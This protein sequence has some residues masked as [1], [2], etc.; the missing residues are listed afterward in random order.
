MRVCCASGCPAW[1]HCAPGACYDAVVVVVVGITVRR[2]FRESQTLRKTGDVERAIELAAVAWQNCCEE[3]TANDAKVRTPVLVGLGLWLGTVG[4]P[5]GVFFCHSHNQRTF[6]GGNG[7]CRSKP[8][9]VLRFTPVQ[10]ICATPSGPRVL[11]PLY[12]TSDCL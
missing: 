6:E 7:L 8:L 2:L 9:S 1:A 12:S 4:T 3:I 5:W 10:I 11:H